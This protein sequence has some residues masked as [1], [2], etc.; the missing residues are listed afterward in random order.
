MMRRSD[1]ISTITF[2]VTVQSMFREDPDTTS[3]GERLLNLIYCAKSRRQGKH[4]S[5]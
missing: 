1:P 3:L 5:G 2:K 4:I